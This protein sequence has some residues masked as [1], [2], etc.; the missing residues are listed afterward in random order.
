MSNSQIV[1]Y[2]V[3]IIGS[4]Y[5]GTMVVIN[6]VR[7]GR[8][9][10]RIAL[11]E[12]RPEFGRGVAYGTTDSKH[13]LNVTAKNMGAFPDYTHHFYHWLQRHPDKLRAVGIDQ[14]WPDSFIPRV[15][16]GSYIQDLLSIAQ[17]HNPSLDLI[18]DEAVDLV[19][20][21][22]GTFRLD[23]RENDPIEADQ[24]VLAVGN[25]PPGD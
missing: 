22:D 25:F 8:R 23:L 14:I 16:Y 11:L 21:S 7:I 10:I 12:R 20:Q 2:D 15:L 5:S 1:K 17:Q 6:L 4:G 24:V 3:L 13:L 19:P 9:N 18:Q